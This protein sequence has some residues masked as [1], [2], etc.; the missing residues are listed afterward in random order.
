MFGNH[1]GNRYDY[2][3]EYK[4]GEIHTTSGRITEA[5]DNDWYWDY[6]EDLNLTRKFSVTNDSLHLYSR[7]SSI[8]FLYISKSLYNQ[9]HY[10]IDS[11]YSEGLRECVLMNK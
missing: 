1:R 9:N 3:Y 8:V 6:I 11:I 4:Q 5:G 2:S 10:P 7:D